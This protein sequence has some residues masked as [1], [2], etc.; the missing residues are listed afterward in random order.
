MIVSSYAHMLYV[1]APS[2][3]LSHTHWV[4][5]PW[6]CTSRSRCIIIL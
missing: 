4:L 2:H 6:I 3:L 1:R 5:I